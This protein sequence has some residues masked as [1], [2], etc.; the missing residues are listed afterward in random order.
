MLKND[1]SR[2][3]D[4]NAIHRALLAGLLGNIGYKSDQTEYMG[5]RG[6]KFS[7]FP[8]STLFKRKPQWLMSAEIVETTKLYART[9]ARID[10]EWIERAAD[11]LVRRTYSEPRWDRERASVVADEKVSLYGL[12]VVPKRTVHYGPIDPKAARSIFIHYALVEGEYDTQAPFFA[13]NRKLVEEVRELEAKARS[14]DYLVDAEV[15]F[16]FYDK[17][18]PQDVFSGASFEKW[19]KGAERHNPKLLFMAR[20]D[21]MKRS[22]DDVTPD[23]FPDF[24]LVAGNRF[25][26]E[27]ELDPGAEADGVTVTVPLAALNQLGPEPFD[28]LV[29]GLLREKVLELLRTLPKPLRVNFVPAPDWADRATEKLTEFFAQGS[30]YEALAVVLG[31]FSGLQVKAADFAPGELPEHLFM[32]YRIVD[33]QGRTIQAGRDLVAI[34]R[35][36]GIEARKTFAEMPPDPR[37]HRDGITRWDFGDLPDRIEIKRYGVT[38]GAYPALVDPGPGATSVSLRLFDSP[39]TARAAHAAGVRRLFMLEMGHELRHLWRRVPNL[40]RMSMNY[41]LL[42]ST[43][44][45]RLQLMTAAA[46]RAFAA[47]GNLR[48]QAAFAARAGSAWYALSTEHQRLSGI[49]NEALGEFYSLS[50]DLGRAFPPLLEPSVLD[51]RTHLVRLMPRD[52]ILATPPQWLEHLPR[53]LRGIGVR[54]KKLTNAGLSRDQ[55]GMETILPLEKQAEERRR[56][57]RAE[58]VID[59]NLTLYRWMLEEYRIS[60]FAQELRTSVPVSPKRL[61]EVWLAVKP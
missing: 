26:L 59:P 51:M 53:F 50:K 8:G 5:A 46:D 1:T 55:Q 60:L 34:Q 17:R 11:H 40:E 29:P 25:A 54:L 31:K 12:P 9:N 47:D 7:V 22:A 27:Y 24:L 10:P 36:L 13:H 45:L 2:Q 42:G 56:K 19:R 16:A 6:T 44:D 57:H 30:L 61:T 43:D 38:L 3:V 32:N 20:R 18:L 28:W 33:Q 48:T 41:K 23:A 49:A 58:G 15:R 39:D 21:L 14:R 35:K 4:Y 37:F 52:F